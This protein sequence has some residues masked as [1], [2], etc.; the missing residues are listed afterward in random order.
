MF[1][2]PVVMLFDHSKTPD[3]RGVKEKT[4]NNPPALPI[5]SII[6]VFVNR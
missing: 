6:N 5:N 2:F 4:K 3:A 1:S